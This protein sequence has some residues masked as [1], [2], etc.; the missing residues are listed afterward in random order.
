MAR[1]TPVEAA[2]DLQVAK[3]DLGISAA[4]GDSVVYVLSYANVGNQGATG[5]A[6]SETVPANTTFNGVASTA[7]MELS[8]RQRRGYGLYFDRGHPRWRPEPIQRASRS[9]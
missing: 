4:P 5:T 1:A 9:P 7:G 3:E 2:P 6:I 8:R